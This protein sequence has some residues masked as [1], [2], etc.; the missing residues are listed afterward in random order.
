MHTN[1]KQIEEM[2][3]SHKNDTTNTYTMT[4]LMVCKT[5]GQVLQFMTQL[6]GHNDAV[7]CE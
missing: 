4:Q 6:S 7:L 2:R 1:V 5:T 3:Q